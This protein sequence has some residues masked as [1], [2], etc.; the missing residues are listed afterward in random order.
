MQWVIK[1][2]DCI[3]S[4]QAASCIWVAALKVYHI[5]LSCVLLPTIK[6]AEASLL[7]LSALCLDPLDLLDSSWTAPLLLFEPLLLLRLSSGWG[8][9]VIAVLLLFSALPLP[10]LDLVFDLPSFGL[11]WEDFSCC[12]RV[13][14]GW[15]S[16]TVGCGWTVGGLNLV[17]DALLCSV[18]LL[19]TTSVRRSSSLCSFAKLTNT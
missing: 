9:L 18:P 1:R 17:G 15:G 2:S 19:M 11:L 4:F 8:N 14:L 3:L 10:L 6:S 12:C 7:E 16:V 13:L 5:A